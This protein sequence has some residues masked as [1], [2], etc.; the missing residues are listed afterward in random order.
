[1]CKHTR[2]FHIISNDCVL[3]QP[4]AVDVTPPPVFSLPPGAVHSP[5]NVPIPGNMMPPVHHMDRQLLPPPPQQ[6]VNMYHGHPINEV[7]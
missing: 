6:G 3:F 7:I 1:M 4:G 5:N 2:V